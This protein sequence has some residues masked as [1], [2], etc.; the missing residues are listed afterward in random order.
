MSAFAVLSAWESDR[1]RPLTALTW[2]PDTPP[3][4]VYGPLD[5]GA[6]PTNGPWPDH[7]GVSRSC[8]SDCLRSGHGLW[9][10]GLA[11]V[12]CMWCICLPKTTM[13][14]TPTSSIVYEPDPVLAIGL[15]VAWWPSGGMRSAASRRPRARGP[16]TRRGAPAILTQSVARKDNRSGPIVGG[17]T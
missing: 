17:S 4:T 11:W 9:I 10:R 7:P 6:W 1:S 16:T 2:A 15:T 12:S 13:L 5:T 3:V 14:L 8:Q